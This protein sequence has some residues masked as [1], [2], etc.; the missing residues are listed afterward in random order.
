[1]HW[2]VNTKTEPRPRGQQ[3]AWMEALRPR[4][5][6]E[7]EGSPGANLGKLHKCTR[8]DR[9]PSSVLK[10]PVA[11]TLSQTALTDPDTHHSRLLKTYRKKTNL[12]HRIH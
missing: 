4:E 8:T 7:T 10:G 9:I 6:M 3:V 2:K 1:M 11:R 12:N 5:T